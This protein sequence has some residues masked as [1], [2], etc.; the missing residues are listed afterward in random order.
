MGAGA[1]LALCQHQGRRPS[2]AGGWGQLRGSCPC[3]GCMPG[4]DGACRGWCRRLCAIRICRPAAAGGGGGSNGMLQRSRGSH[5]GSIPAALSAAGAA[6]GQRRAWAGRCGGSGAH[7]VLCQHVLRVPAAWQGPA[8]VLSSYPTPVLNTR[9]QLLRPARAGALLSGCNL[10]LHAPA[11]C[12]GWCGGYRRT[13][14]TWMP[15]ATQ[16]GIAQ[17]DSAGRWLHCTCSRRLGAAA[18]VS[19]ASKHAASQPRSTTPGRRGWP[20]HPVEECYPLE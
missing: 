16:R 9:A 20:R 1:G 4:Q 6:P 7:G 13:A 3:C 2:G 5:R 8:Q 18:C 17:A 15:W 12:A 11:P 19:P 14:P 10:Q